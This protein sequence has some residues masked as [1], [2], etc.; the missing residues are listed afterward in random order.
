MRPAARNIIFAMAVPST[1]SII[2]YICLSSARIEMTLNAGKIKADISVPTAVTAIGLSSVA[3]T[4]DP[5][6]VLAVTAIGLSSEATKAVAIVL[7][8][9]STTAATPIVLRSVRRV[10]SMFGFA[11]G[12]ATPRRR[13]RGD[14]L[15]RQMEI[16]FQSLLAL[17][18]L[19]FLAGV[20]AVMLRTVTPAASAQLG[21][22]PV[23]AT[24][25]FCVLCFGLMY[26]PLRDRGSH[27]LQKRLC[28]FLWVYP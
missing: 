26:F 13:T 27:S 6:I 10:A 5:S 1:S 22:V 8:L 9:V 3:R 2:G 11:S 23:S 28:F 24:I 17:A 16:H 14:T 12:H 7:G 15:P 20:S 18:W 4:A 19:H 25:D 21:T